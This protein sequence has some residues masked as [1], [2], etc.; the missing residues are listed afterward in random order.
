MS[1]PQHRKATCIA[2][3]MERSCSPF[4]LIVWEQQSASGDDFKPTSAAQPV[5]FQGMTFQAGLVAAKQSSLIF[6]F[7]LSL[8]ARK[9][10]T[11]I[12]YRFPAVPL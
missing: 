1:T 4:R 12:L 10:R 9:M 7:T 5:L 6:D 3:W 11:C 2:A 8:V